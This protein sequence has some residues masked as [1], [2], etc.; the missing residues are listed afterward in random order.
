MAPKS[1]GGKS[2]SG[3][4]TQA[5]GGV[6]GSGTTT[7]PRTIQTR[8]QKAGLQVRLEMSSADRFS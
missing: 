7:T 8:S 3:A 1:T 5:A 4:P 2:K 6:A